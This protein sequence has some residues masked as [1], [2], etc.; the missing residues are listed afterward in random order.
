MN[1]AERKR[2]EAIRLSYCNHEIQ[3]IKYC[4]F[5]DN[6]STIALYDKG[7]AKVYLAEKRYA[8]SIMKSGDKKAYDMAKMCTEAYK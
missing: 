7:F 4:D 1:R 2:K 3:T 5:I 6:T 8:L